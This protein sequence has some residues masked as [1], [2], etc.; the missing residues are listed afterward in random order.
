MSQAFI[1]STHR[2]SFWHGGRSP[3]LTNSSWNVFLYKNGALN[4]ERAVR[5]VSV[6]VSQLGEPKQPVYEAFFTDDGEE[7]VVWTLIVKEKGYEEVAYG[8]SWFVVS[9]AGRENMSFIR[10][11]IVQLENA[12]RELL[13]KDE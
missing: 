4:K 9:D 12:T 5:V 8:E 11:K 3:N 7:N 6:G 13:A 2:M 10:N 1:N